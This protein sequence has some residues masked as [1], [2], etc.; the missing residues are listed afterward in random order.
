MAFPTNP[1]NG[2]VYVTTTKSF[3][4]YDS[5]DDKWYKPKKAIIPWTP[6]SILPYLIGWYDAS[7][8]STIILGT[9]SNISQIDDKSGNDYHLYNPNGG[10]LPTYLEDGMNELNVIWGEGTLDNLYK[11]NIPD[12]VLTEAA[13][14][15][16]GMPKTAG[17]YPAFGDITST[18][19]TDSVLNRGQCGP[20]V[21]K[22]SCSV[23]ID[24]SSVSLVG[25][26]SVEFPEEREC[27]LGTWFNSTTS[28]ARLNGGTLSDTKSTP[29]GTFTLNR[30][31]LGRQSNTPKNYTGEMI[32]LNTADIDIIESVE[33]YLAW[34]WGIVPY[35]SV[36]HPYK[37]AAPTA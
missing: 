36:S 32:V 4:K 8:S 23:K 30:I 17:D 29:S 16:A 13:I 19:N 1:E 2:D 27:I 3:Y 18:D 24:S 21:G 10:Q 35:L 5:I 33:G 34:K 37:T 6:Y 26:N 12:T 11:D 31:R 22:M 14:I 28:T 20:T 15:T 25:S 9:G 7:D